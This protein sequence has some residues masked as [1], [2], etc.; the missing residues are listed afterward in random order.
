MLWRVPRFA[1]V[2]PLAL[3]AS[4]AI[5]VTAAMADDSV[6]ID[7]IA[8]QVDGKVVL[9]SEVMRAVAPQEEA[10]RRAGAPDSEIAKLRAEG[11]ERLIESRLIE[12]IVERADLH[13]SDEEIDRAIEGI[14][15]EN[16]LTLEQLYAS[17]VFHGMSVEQYRAQ[18]KSDFEH[19]NVVNA[20]VGQRVKVNDADVRTFYDDRVAG[21]GGG[22]PSVHVR[23]ILRAYGGPSKRDQK[24]ACAEASE[25][26]ARVSAG[27]PFEQVAAQVSEVAP[28][29]GGDIGWV[30]LDSVAPW[31]SEALAPLEPGQMSDVLVLP[32]GCAVLQLV[33]QRV[34]E[35]VSFEQAKGRISQE[36]WERQVET[37]Y[38]KWMEELREHSYIERKGYF[39]D[40]AKL[41][42]STFPVRSAPAGK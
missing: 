18:I 33:E 9:V 1:R 12:E 15:E 32:F 31:M 25:A 35:P 19:R 24:T 21:Q 40:A 37:E 30:P 42:D 28:R 8:A 5:A 20:M 38:R 22:G 27:E 2:L 41:G 4:C 23:Q 11:L 7:G 16:G 6:M 10:L 26:R 17:V 36:L 39:A 13:A 3:A 29:D 34:L 14:A